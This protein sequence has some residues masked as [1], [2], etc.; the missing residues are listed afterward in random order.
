MTTD[1]QKY[2]YSTELRDR[3]DRYDEKRELMDKFPGDAYLTLI[4]IFETLNRES[5]DVETVDE[6]ILHYVDVRLDDFGAV[7][8]GC[9]GPF[10]FEEPFRVAWFLPERGEWVWIDEIEDSEEEGD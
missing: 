10:S 4:D 3:A 1:K 9:H 8:P 7:L 2:K 5:F 6:F